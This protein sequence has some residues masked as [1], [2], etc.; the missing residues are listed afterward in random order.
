M[1]YLETFGGESETNN[2]SYSEYLNQGPSSLLDP[3]NASDISFRTISTRDGYDM[4]WRFEIAEH[5]GDALVH[6]VA[7]RTVGSPSIQWD[8][9]IGYP[10]SWSPDGPPPQWWSLEGNK[11]VCWLL[12]TG[13]SDQRKHGWYFQYESKSQTMY[14][15]HWNHQWS[16]A[17]SP[18]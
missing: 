12:H 8:T 4:W 7:N 2:I 16:S 15:W 13:S 18:H 3:V 5:D 9:T 10:S 1:T 6:S 14:C 11:S 17:S